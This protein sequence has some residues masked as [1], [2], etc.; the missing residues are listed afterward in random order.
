MATWRQRE[1]PSPKG[2]ISRSPRLNNCNVSCC[3]GLRVLLSNVLEPCHKLLPST[4]SGFLSSSWVFVAEAVYLWLCVFLITHSAFFF[5]FPQLLWGQIYLHTSVSMA[6]KS[7]LPS[8][9][10]LTRLV[11]AKHLNLHCSPIISQLS[12]TWHFY[13]AC[14]FFF[15]ESISPPRR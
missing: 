11:F 3:W 13:L 6:L 14:F 9:L 8:S 10:F 2:C 1:E 7:S 12:Y 4:T 5:F 15:Q